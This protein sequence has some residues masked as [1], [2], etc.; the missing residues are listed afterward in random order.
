M[1]RLPAFLLA[2]LLATPLLAKDHV[3]M[4]KSALAAP[5][6]RIIN[7]TPLQINIGSDNS[8]Q[9][10]NS[11]VG[12]DGQFYPSGANQTADSGW[13]VRVGNTLYAPNFNEH[14]GGSA[15]G[16]LG[17][18]VDFSETSLSAV[19]GAGT[20][21]SPFTVTVTTALGASG[22]TAVKTTS[23]VNGDS[24]Y[25][26]RFRLVNGNA[27]PV[28][29]RIYLGS[30]IYL[31]DSDAGVPYRE[32]VSGSVGGRTC[33]AV[34]TEYTILHIPLSVATRT[35]ATGYASVWSQIGSGNLDNAVGS[36]CIDNGAALQ[37]DVDVPPGGSKTIL[38]AT[39]FGPIPPV[40]QFNITDVNP[41]LGTVGTTVDVA[42]SGFG[43]TPQTTFTFGLGITVSNIFVA[44]ST[45]A[46]A[47]L[48][49]APNAT[50]GYRDVIALQAPGGLSATLIDGFGVTDVPV[51]NYSVLNGG[52]VHP[53]ALNCIRARFPASP[54]NAEGWAPDEGTWYVDQ[55]PLPPFPP[56]IPPT[57]LPRAIL[58][59]YVNG[60]VWNAA[61]GTLHPEYC[62]DVGSPS[63]QGE[64][65][66][67]RVANLRIYQATN[68]Q[69][70]GVMPGATIFES[71]VSIVRQEFLLPPMVQSGFEDR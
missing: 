32:P 54:R 43:F 70:V 62:W 50:F 10:F 58:D 2:L 22:L 42:I 52:N 19:A 31:A 57:G 17:A 53:T 44:N 40:A 46:S 9:I 60:F 18:T 37:W 30:D 7:G 48:T 4:P 26:E 55:P 8:Y 1:N 71:N 63:Y 67:L 56:P 65:P 13:F 45:T 24:F 20:T 6:V 12:G 59:C 41:S 15:T 39:S 3:P 28:P 11:V 16:S 35:T 38:A 5:T 47:L 27:G 29:A 25:T 36:G 21:A 66:F 51:F 23:Y 33:P 64:F 61:A 68:F 49:I 69:C 14:P 34:P